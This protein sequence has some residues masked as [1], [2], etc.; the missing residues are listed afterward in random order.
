MEA[1]TMT[2]VT[3]LDPPTPQDAS[4]SALPKFDPARYATHVDD[5]DLTPAQQ[6]DV[7][8][9][10]WTIMTGFVDMGFGVESVQ[11]FLPELGKLSSEFRKNALNIQDS[12]HAENFNDVANNRKDDFKCEP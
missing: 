2:D 6:E 3:L 4:H 5:L 9:A 12:K 7:L 8:R 1:C 11:N 10:L